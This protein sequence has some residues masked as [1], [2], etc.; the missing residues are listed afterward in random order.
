VDKP[1]I[2]LDEYQML[3]LTQDAKVQLLNEGYEPPEFFGFM[4]GCASGSKRK[5]P[6]MFDYDWVH[7]IS[8]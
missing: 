3:D 8:I 1:I 5:L 2:E 6:L 7:L 4:C